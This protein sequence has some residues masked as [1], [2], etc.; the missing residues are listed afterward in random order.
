MDL[1]LAASFALASYNKKKFFAGVSYQDRVDRIYKLCPTKLDPIT[2]FPAVGGGG[3]R[4]NVINHYISVVGNFKA[5]YIIMVK[6][7]LY[8]A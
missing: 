4:I 6:D 1:H 8:I 5:Y 7:T 3:G 2:V